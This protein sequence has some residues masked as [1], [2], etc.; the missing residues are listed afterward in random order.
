[1]EEQLRTEQLLRE[2]R[3]AALPVVF[4]LDEFDR[5]AERPKQKLL[6]NLFDLM[7]QPNV[8]MAVVGLTSRLDP[9]DL[10]EKRIKS[11]FSNRQIL[12]LP[13]HALAVRRRPAVRRP[14]IPGRPSTPCATP[15][16]TP[17]P[18][19]ASPKPPM[20]AGDFL[21]ACPDAS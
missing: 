12:L 14:A 11:R 6:Y 7:Q 17:T 1:M 2:G 19:A 18:P 16:A 3:R 15:P 4:V 20:H 13:P 21:R 10:L 9:I 5:F 8:T